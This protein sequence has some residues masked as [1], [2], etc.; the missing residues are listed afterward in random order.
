MAKKISALLCHAIAAQTEK[1]QPVIQNLKIGLHCDLFC[2]FIQAVQVRID[3]F[4]APDADDVGVRIGPV[5]VVP[6][7]PIREAQLENLAKFLDQYNIS[8][9]GGEAHGRK[10]S[11]YLA[12]D[13]FNAGM[14]FAMGK[15]LHDRHSLGGYL[16]AVIP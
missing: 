15:N 11:F 4:S 3:Y 7:A 10:V 16:V 2:H 9:N 6:V 14:A 8:I 5:A 1:I 12:M 13:I